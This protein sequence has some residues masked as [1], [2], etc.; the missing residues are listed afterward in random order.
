MECNTCRSATKLRAMTQVSPNDPTPPLHVE[1]Q[2]G[3][4]TSRSDA[5]A[6]SKEAAQAAK[7]DGGSTKPRSPLWWWVLGIVC[8]LGAELYVYGHNGW[9]RVCVGMQGVTDLALLDRPRHRDGMKGFPICTEQLNLGM[10]SR[11]EDAAREALEVVCTRGAT[12]L[13]GA[14]QDCLRKDHG[15]LRRVD[16]ENIPPWDERLYRRLLFLD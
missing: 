7:Q 1:E 6:D 13:R 10:Y 16:K 5:T 2:A 9:I 15:W 3:G 14:K 8:V 12:L 4:S 11:S